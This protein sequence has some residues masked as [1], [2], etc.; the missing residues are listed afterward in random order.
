MESRGGK[1]ECRQAV[2]GGILT[3]QVE[4]SLQVLLSDLDIAQ[5][6]T[7]VFVAEQLHERR[8]ADAH[9]EHFSG[10]GVPELVR[11]HVGRAVGSCGGIGQ[12]N[13]KGAIQ[14]IFAASPGQEPALGDGPSHP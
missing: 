4:L 3:C 5:G 2:Q 12:R 9:T 8:Q 10:V 7:D 1:G 6:H 11:R 13:P 14:G